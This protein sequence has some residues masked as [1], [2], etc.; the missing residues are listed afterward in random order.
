MSGVNE[1]VTGKGTNN[2]LQMVL[3]RNGN[4]STAS[5]L[6]SQA[7]YGKSCNASPGNMTGVL[8]STCNGRDRCEYIVDYKVIGDPAPGCRKDFAA[9][10]RCTGTAGLHHLTLPGE[11]GRGSLATIRCDASTLTAN[12][13]F[14]PPTN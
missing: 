9:E 4:S 2:D 1:I 13:S 8:A 5:I 7:T 3:T 12:P 6:V 10:W 11:A 14:K